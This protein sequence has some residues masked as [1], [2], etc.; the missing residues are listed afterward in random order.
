M[1]ESRICGLKNISRAWVDGSCNHKTSNITDHANSEPHKAAMV[2]FRKSR[3]EPVTNY[4]PIARSL[5]SSLM[6][7]AVREQVKKKF[8]ISFVLERV[9]L[10]NVNASRLVQLEF[11]RDQPC[12]TPSMYCCGWS[13]V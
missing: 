12:P 5:L 8:D 10:M 6:A 7:P 9:V 3:N 4:N 13:S 11:G 2:Y 1:Y